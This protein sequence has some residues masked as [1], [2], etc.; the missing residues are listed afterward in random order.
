MILNSFPLRRRVAPYAARLRCLLVFITLASVGAATSSVAATIDEIRCG[1]LEILGIYG[2]FDYRTA[3]ALQKHLVESGH[4]T[5]DVESLIRGNGVVTPGA[6]IAYTLRAFPNHPRALKAMMEL[7]FKEKTDKPYNVKWPVDCWFNRA[8]RYAPDDPQVRMV[9]AIYL[10]RIGK[11]KLAVEQLE[12][13]S[14]MGASSANYH[15]NLGLAYFQVQEYEKARTQA[16]KAKE[17]GYEL[18]GLKNLLTRAGQ[19]REKEPAASTSMAP[20]PAAPETEAP[21]K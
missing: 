9:Y 5:P 21:K 20:Q 13:A 11:K 15:Y 7:G 4:F 8:L 14:T 2:P 18:E 19:W 3:T 16:Y 12:T 6:D 1:P 10:M 17:L